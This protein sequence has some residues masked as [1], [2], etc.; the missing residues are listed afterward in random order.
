MNEQKNEQKM[1]K[2]A[3]TIEIILTGIVI[4]IIPLL[5]AIFGGITGWIIDLTR[6]GGWIRLVLNRPDIT[7]VQ[8]GSTLG[9]I[10]SFLK[11]FNKGK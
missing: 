4:V 10:V 11:F 2:L 1:G 8:L 9:F 5:M 3:E 6:I 7:M